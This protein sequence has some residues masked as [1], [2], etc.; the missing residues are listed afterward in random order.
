MKDRRVASKS[1]SLLSVTERQHVST[2]DALNM[3]SKFTF[4]TA[5]LVQRCTEY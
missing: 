3:S 5:E 4:K 1:S 2:R